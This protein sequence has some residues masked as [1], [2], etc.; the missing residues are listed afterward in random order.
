[1]SCAKMAEPVEIPFWIWT[2]VDPSIK[3]LLG[4]VHTGATWGI[5][6]NHPYAAAMQPVVK[7]L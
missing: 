6:L 7:L 3:P 1:M 5:P 2:R 4:G